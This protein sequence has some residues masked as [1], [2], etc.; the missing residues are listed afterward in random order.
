MKKM[1]VAYCIILMLL[2]PSVAASVIII[3]DKNRHVEKVSNKIS[4]IENNAIELDSIFND[5][6]EK[7]E[8]A[9]G[10]EECKIIFKETL[11]ELDEN[12]LLGNVSVDNAYKIICDSYND[13]NSYSVCGESNHT[14][15]LEHTG[16]FFYELSKRFEYFFGLFC[17][18]MYNI[19]LF[20][21]RNHIIHTGSYVT[22]G[23][24]DYDWV[25]LLK[26]FPAE[27]Y[28]KI[29]DSNGETEYNSFFGHLEF[30]NQIDMMDPE[31]GHSFYCIGIKGF[32][33]ILINNYY[34]GTAKEVS[35]GT[36]APDPYN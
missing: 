2:L 33:G 3:P 25:T 36:D 6:K 1:L 12:N 24:L 21:N 26:S 28:I 17:W 31:W 34:F 7:M 22:F 14:Y 18:F 11:I 23:V 8:N 13:G 29:V 15:F 35:I 5:L 10:Q 9:D 27:G 32:K 20:G 19:F 30:I 4:L 16:V